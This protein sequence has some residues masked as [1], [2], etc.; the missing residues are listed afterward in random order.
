[1]FRGISHAPRYAF[2]TR[3]VRNDWRTLFFFAGVLDAERRLL[4]YFQDDL[5]IDSNWRERP[6]YAR[7]AEAGW[8]NMDGEP[9]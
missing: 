6:Q 3:K 8:E 4:L 9:K 5:R 2:T 1:V 7:T